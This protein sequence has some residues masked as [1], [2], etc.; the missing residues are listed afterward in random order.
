VTIDPASLRPHYSR[1]LRGERILLTG[2]SHQA[3]PDVA[4]DAQLEAFDDAATH[5]DDKWGAAMAAA[6]ALRE[7]AARRLGGRAED[8]ALASNTHELGARFLSSLDLR[9]RPHLVTT[10]G[11][12]HS[13]RRQLTRL[14]EEGIALTVVDPDPLDTLA[15]RLAAAVRETTAA[16]LC[17]TVLFETAS[18]VPHLRALAETCHARGAALLLDAYHHYNAV[19]W[20]PVAPRAFVV[21]GGYKYAQYG[22]GCC[23][24][25]VPEGCTSRPV[26][27]GWF[28]DFGG[29]E[30]E[31]ET[32]RYGARGAD[33]F[34]GSTYDPTSHYRARAVDAFFTDQALSVE[35]LRALSLRQTGRLIGKLEEHVE[36]LTPR[37]DA[38]RGGFVSVRVPAAAEVV[39]GLRERGVYVDARRD[40]LRFGPA[41]YTTDDEIDAGVEAFVDVLRGRS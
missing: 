19:P 10:G 24:L 22:E 8:Y 32:I 7:A 5:V 23:F 16:A 38:R 12:F 18:V 11:E 36:V 6:D 41:P 29:L 14:A 34:A 3:W 26:Y 21:G 9:A 20:E 39:R 1:F 37:D 30:G 33:R 25:R 28:A 31:Q 35:R 2:H 13:L 40:R 15:E 17:S 27:T 4:R